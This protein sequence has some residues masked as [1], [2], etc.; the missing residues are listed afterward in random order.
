MSDDTRRQHSL[1]EL[2]LPGAD[3]GHRIGQE[4]ADHSAGC[5]Q[6]KPMQAS[7]EETGYQ[8]EDEMGSEVMCVIRAQ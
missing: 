7:D 8:G 1:N 3:G 6:Q 4:N 5:S 2:T